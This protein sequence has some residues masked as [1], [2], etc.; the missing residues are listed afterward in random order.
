MD[1]KIVRFK[2]MQDELGVSERTLYTLVDRGLPCLQVNRVIWF[3]RG[4][5]FEW[6]SQFERRGKRKKVAKEVA[7]K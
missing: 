2:A 7:S 3:D 6:L 1:P 4:K 5:V